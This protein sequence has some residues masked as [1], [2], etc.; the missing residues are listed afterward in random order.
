M[1]TYKVGGWVVSERKF[2]ELYDITIPHCKS[3][4]SVKEKLYQFSPLMWTGKDWYFTQF[5]KEDE[6][7]REMR[8]DE[9]IEFCKVNN[10]RIG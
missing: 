1:D 7:S 9:I 2:F 6:V 8:T 4:D 3:W 10:V 5:V